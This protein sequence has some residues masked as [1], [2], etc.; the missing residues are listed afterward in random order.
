MFST[1]DLSKLGFDFGLT[2]DT[3]PNC[4]VT[5]NPRANP[6]NSSELV[7]GITCYKS[8]IVTFINVHW[9]GDIFKNMPINL[10]VL[11]PADIDYATV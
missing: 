3:M 9:D 1:D 8:T 2:T 7:V 10:G 5:K 4:K 6:D 11:T